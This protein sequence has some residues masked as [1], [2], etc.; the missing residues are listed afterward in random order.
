M[1]LCMQ[2]VEW[3]VGVICSLTVMVFEAL[4]HCLFLLFDMVVV[5]DFDLG[6]S[7]D[8]GSGSGSEVE[9]RHVLE[10]SQAVQSASN[11]ESGSRSGFGSDSGSAAEPELVA[12]FAIGR[13]PPVADK[14]P[15]RHQGLS[16]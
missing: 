7:F 6:C 14:S 5:V 4:L 2:A 12:N 9:G 16:D 11:L 3:V 8:S 15:S 10:Y 1:F 13:A